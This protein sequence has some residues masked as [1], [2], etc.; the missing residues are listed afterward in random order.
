MRQTRLIA[1]FVALALAVTAVAAEGLKSGPQPGEKVPGAFEPLNVTGAGA[2]RKACLFCKHG[3]NPVVMIFA[4][5][6]SEP[7][8]RLIKRVDQATAEHK[9]AKM[10]SFVV[11]LSD[12]PQMSDK[13]KELADREQIRETVLGLQGPTG[14]EAYKVSP[15]ADVTVVLYTKRQVKANRAFARGELQ[16]RDIDA[17]VSEVGQ[18]LP[19]Q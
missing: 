19:Q 3:N 17:I 11:F 1:V 13:L 15:D 9:D 8:T 12:S 2:G 16:D 10:G 5:E 14:P 18:I 7:L 4:R 6:V